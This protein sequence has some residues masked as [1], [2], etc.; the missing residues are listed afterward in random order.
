MPPT[1]LT[2]I[3]LPAL[4]ALALMCSSCRS[5]NASVDIL[6]F[7]KLMFETPSSDLPKA[8]SDFQGEYRSPLLRI[9][10]SDENYM[11]TFHDFAADSVVRQI[12]SI[13]NQKMGDLH[14]L[15][16]ELGGAIAKSD[17]LMPTMHLEHIATYISGM[18]DYQNRILVDKGTQSAL[19]SL[20]LY[21]VD[22]MERYSFFGLPQYL[23]R[24]SDTAYLATDLMAEW[25]R[26]FIAAPE[27]S[28]VTLLDLMV[29]E[30]K[31]LYYL[32]LVFPGANDHIKLRYTPQQ[33]Q[34]CQKNEAMLWSYFISHGL[35]YE[36]DFARYHNFIDEAPFTNAFKDSA[37]RTPEYLG[38][39]IVR[40]YMRKSGATLAELFANSDSQAILNTSS[41]KP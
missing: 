33:L 37:P 5:D 30:G 39:Q 2:T 22:G 1:R 27:E 9:Y 11:A 6:R 17:E 35:L 34:W 32:D 24:Q 36:K 12:Y 19:I 10:P 26:H 4:V 41:Y 25:A 23:V 20:D 15:E 28:D 3:L 40:A 18:F 14:W 13:T 8:L 38:L 7:D 31:A 16:R 21:A 29:M